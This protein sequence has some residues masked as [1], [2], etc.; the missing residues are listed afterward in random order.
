MKLTKKLLPLLLTVTLLMAVS[1]ML[2]TAC[3]STP[4]TTA[5]TDMTSKPVD[6]VSQATLN[7]YRTN[8]IQEYK[9][10]RLDPAVGPRDNSMSGVRYANIDTYKLK[11]FGLVSQP[12]ELTY[13]DVVDMTYDQRLITLYCVEGW[14]ATILWQGVRIE[15]L[16][17]LAGE[18][19]PTAV[20]VIFHAIDGYTTSLPLSVIQQNDLIMAYQANGLPLPPEMGYPFI[21]VAEDKLGYKWCRWVT[22]IE[23]SNDAD[24]LGYWERL[25]YSN[26]AD[27]G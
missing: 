27:I 21:V 20:T 14:E 18:T 8:E 24:Y 10:M 17:A 2:S 6:T 25:G 1:A 26:D 3:Q 12:V 13:A 4:G 11:I 19:D 23:L 9:G 15:E 7:R 5:A 16:I 22:H